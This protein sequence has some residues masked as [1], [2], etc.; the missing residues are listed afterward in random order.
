MVQRFIHVVAAALAL[1]V[2][3]AAPAALAADCDNGE[4]ATK[5]H[6]K[7]RASV[8]RQ[9]R[10]RAFV[11]VPHIKMTPPRDLHVMPYQVVTAPAVYGT[12]TREVEVAP[13]RAHYV[14]VPAVYGTVTREVAVAGGNGHH[15]HHRHDCRCDDRH[16]STTRTVTQRVMLQAPKRVLHYTPAVRRSVEQPVLLRPAT[17][18]VVVP[19]LPT[20]GHHGFI[21]HHRG[22]RADWGWHGHRR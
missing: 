8:Y 12:I 20:G 13:A 22:N 9:E 4:C 17:R 3:L 5:Q 1:P 16:H 14:D 2:L 21:P 18:H 10:A 19:A 11:R 7:A 6:A 15:A